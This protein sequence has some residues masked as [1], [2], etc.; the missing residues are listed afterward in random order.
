[1]SEKLYHAVIV[2]EVHLLVMAEADED[3]ASVKEKA[4]DVFMIMLQ[5]KPLQETL[6]VTLEE[7]A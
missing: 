4:L 6:S 1:M 5:D 7:V 2:A 3:E